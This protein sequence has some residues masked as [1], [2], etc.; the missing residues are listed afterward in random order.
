MI[1]LF[2]DEVVEISNRMVLLHWIQRA[3][4]LLQESRDE[5]NRVEGRTPNPGVDGFFGRGAHEHRSEA[6]VEFYVKLED[7]VSVWWV[8]DG[9]SILGDLERR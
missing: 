6:V 1:F 3:M 2:E 8:E 9:I 4:L 7:W 5:T